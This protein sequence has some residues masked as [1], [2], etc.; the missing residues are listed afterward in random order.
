MGQYKGRQFEIDAFKKFILSLPEDNY[1]DKLVEAREAIVAN[2]ENDI[3]AFC[4]V[5]DWSGENEAL[6]EQVEKL[7]KWDIRRLRAD[8]EALIVEREGYTRK[9]DECQKEINRIANMILGKED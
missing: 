7:K 9:V 6:R 8:Q 1:F 2:I 3:P 5:F 4:G